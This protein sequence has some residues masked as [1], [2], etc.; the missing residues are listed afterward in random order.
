MTSFTSCDQNLSKI[1]TDLFDHWRNQ[2]ITENFLDLEIYICAYTQFQDYRDRLAYT[3]GYIN[4]LCGVAGI[5]S[6]FL[7][8]FTMFKN[9]E[10]ASISYCHYESI[11]LL[12]IFHMIFII[13]AGYQWINV[14][15]YLKSYSWYWIMQRVGYVVGNFLSCCVDFLTIFLSVERA[16]ACW[17]PDKFLLLSRRWQATVFVLLA[18]LFTLGVNTVISTLTTHI[19]LNTVI[20]E[21]STVLIDQQYKNYGIAAEFLFFSIAFS[22]LFSTVGAVMGMLRLLHQR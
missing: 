21:Y 9:A 3:I 7:V 5:L 8:L 4:I 15:V 13:C 6:S 1:D 10:F 16:I 11:A 17:K 18:A 20:M 19:K 2:S 22:A 14:R 12:E